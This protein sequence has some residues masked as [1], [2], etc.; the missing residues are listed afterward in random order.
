MAGALRR[1]HGDPVRR[2]VGDERPHRLDDLRH[3][4]DDA[5]EGIGGDHGERRHV[6]AEQVDLR[7]REVPPVQTVT[8]RPL[9]ERVVDI[10]DVLDVVDLVPGI[11]QDA[12][13]DVER[14]VG[15]RVAQVRRVV[16]GDS[17]DVEPGHRPRVERTH[18][19]AAAVEQAQRLTVAG[20]GGDERCGPRLHRAS[21]RCGRYSA[22][23]GMAGHP[24][25]GSGCRRLRSRD[26]VRSDRARTSL[27]V[28]SVSSCRPGRPC[29]AARRVSSR[30]RSGS[31]TSPRPIP[32]ARSAASARPRG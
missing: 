6:L 27:R 15:R 17:A 19:P 28:M 26:A 12:I 29:S 1:R 4:L 21:V 9:Q 24:G 3:R 32:T 22:G 30:W 31:G 10:R 5:D 2:S 8:C 7:G 14:H 16:R 23:Q 20:H 18:G 13:D 11:P 25:S